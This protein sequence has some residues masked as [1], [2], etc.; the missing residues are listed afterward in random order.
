MSII[1]IYIIPTLKFTTGLLLWLE[2]VGWLVLLFPFPCNGF[3]FGPRLDDNEMCNY[4]LSS[5]NQKIKKYSKWEINH[6][7]EDFQNQSD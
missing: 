4:V 3:L 5:L 7:K 6:W 1:Y 2:L